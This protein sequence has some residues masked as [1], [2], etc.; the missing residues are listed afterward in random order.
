MRSQMW[1]SRSLRGVLLSALAATVVL[2]F[3]L[4]PARSQERGEENTPAEPLYQGTDPARHLHFYKP[5]PLDVVLHPNRLEGLEERRAIRLERS[6]I[7]LVRGST[8]LRRIPF[9][10]DA[11]V[12]FEAVVRAI[13]DRAWAERIGPQTLV[14]RSAFVQAP[15]TSVIFGSP[16]VRVLRLA[17]RPHVFIGGVGARARFADVVVTSW[18]ERVN[19][20]DTFLRN[21][22]PF[23]SYSEGSRLDIVRSE[24]SYLGW[25]ATSAYGLDWRSRATGSV[26]DSEIH[27]NFFGLYS[28]E[29]VGLEVRNNVVRDNV[30]YGI[31][32]HDFSSGLTITDNEVYGNGS[33]G[34]ILS[35]GVTNSVVRNNHS[36]DN[37]ANGIVMD[38]ESNGNVVADNLVEHNQGDGIVILGSSRTLVS[39]NTVRHNR[40]GIRVNQ[41]SAGNS[42]T[43]NRLEDNVR[44]VELYGG[45]RDIHLSGNQI[46][47]SSGAGMVL[48]APASISAGD[49]VTGSPIGIDVRS[50]AEI[51]RTR[52]S[53]VD[54]GVVVSGRGIAALGHL[55][56]EALDTG[57][58][59][60]P[61]ALVRLDHSDIEAGRPV[62]GR[63]RYSL[64][65]ELRR[66]PSAWP[67]L[68]LAGVSF[69]SAAVV[70]ELMH[71]ARNRLFYPPVSRPLPAQDGR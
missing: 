45:A 9:N 5:S 51:R 43:E 1:V 13:R 27:H 20:P 50:L 60:A 14:L 47:D 69:L 48:E 68:P 42:L 25:D 32:P 41:V 61:A 28:Y 71:W 8:V 55:R 39:G 19:R 6:A 33:H 24:I 2:A 3:G 34:I 21:G 26:L 52:V 29:A 23:V 64:G 31:D 17:A 38:F 18:N 4:A 59:V 35:H 56:V 67:W 16:Q 10:G 7:A 57:V 44:G 70:L 37:G 36:H 62:S 46:S 58:A 15:G 66:P 22:R 54:R 63:L 12:P 40:V 49:V 53:D 11:P 30:F 65:N